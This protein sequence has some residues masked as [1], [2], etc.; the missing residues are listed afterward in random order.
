[1]K[2]IENGNDLL[3][4]ANK[5][6]LLSTTTNEVLE[7]T[8]NDIDLV[9]TP[10][11]TVRDIITQYQGTLYELNRAKKEQAALIGL[12]SNIPVELIQALT[13]IEGSLAA[14]ASIMKVS[15]GVSA[16]ASLEEILGLNQNDEDDLDFDL[17]LEEACDCPS[18]LAETD[19]ADKNVAPTLIGASGF[20]QTNDPEVNLKLMMAYQSL[21]SQAMSGQISMMQAYE[22]FQK[23]LKSTP[24][25]NVTL[26]ETRI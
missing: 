1:M 16:G 18:C 5:A 19:E 23:I 22:E 3:G 17:G 9:V 4:F 20:V 15:G 11:S 24:G 14:Q 13:L 25:V 7:A 10:N 6:I 21:M 26:T 12:N 2:I 8:F